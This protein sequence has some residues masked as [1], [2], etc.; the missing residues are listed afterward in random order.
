MLLQSTLAATDSD[1]AD[2]GGLT[3]SITTNDPSG[4]VFAVSGTALTMTAQ[5]YENPGCGSGSDSLTCV[6]VLAATDAA[7]TATAHTITVTITDANDQAPAWTTSATA[8]VAEGATAV[9]T[10]AATDSDTADSGGLT[11]SITTN[12][13]SGTVFAVSGTALTMTAQDYES[14]ACGSGSD[15]TQVSESLL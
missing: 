8:S 7:N 15:S 6:V 2:S 1:T 9:A 14:P 13:P 11:Y 3:Y 10:L 12:D 4:T 5:D